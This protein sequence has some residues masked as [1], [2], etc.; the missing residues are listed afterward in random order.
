MRNQQVTGSTPAEGSIFASVAQRLVRLP[1]KQ[2]M[3]VRFRSLAQFD[4]HIAQ[5][6]RAT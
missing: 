5:L 4:E 2:R 6:A 1:S 3:T